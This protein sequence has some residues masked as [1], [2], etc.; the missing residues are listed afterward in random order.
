MKRTIIKTY[1]K[2]N[3]PTILNVLVPIAFHGDT[4]AMELLI[5]HINRM[6]FVVRDQY[7]LG[8]F[9]VLLNDDVSHIMM[10]VMVLYIASIQEM[11]NCSVT[12][13]IVHWAAFV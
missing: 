11:M 9:G 12:S 13:Q 8:Y 7:V 5:V 2:K 4:C 1:K 3:A 6:K 10:C